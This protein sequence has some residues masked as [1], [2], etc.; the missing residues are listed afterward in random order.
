LS[1]DDR[2]P[3]YDDRRLVINYRRSVKEYRRPVENNI[4]SVINFRWWVVNYRRTLNGDVFLGTFYVLVFLMFYG[5][6]LGVFVI[7]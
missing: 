7:K 5:G 4:R 3:V 1:V 6:F 2:G